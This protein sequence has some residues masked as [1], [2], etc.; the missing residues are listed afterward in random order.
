MIKQYF[1][2]KTIPFCKDIDTENIFLSSSMK[3]LFSRLEYMKQMRGI[4]LLTGTAGSGKTL[5]IRYFINSLNSNCYLPIY[6]PLTTVS[7]IDFYRQLCFK[8]TGEEEF[9]KWKCFE[10]IQRG[11]IDSVTNNKKVPVIV[12]DEAQLLKSENLFEIQIILNFDID[13][14]DPV[15]FILVG[16][17]Y[18]KDIIT[19]PIHG[20]LNQRFTLKYNITSLEKEEVKRYIEHHLKICGVTK[21]IFT[22]SS[23]EAIYNNTGG[24]PRGIGNIATKALTL[25]SIEKKQTITEEEIYKVSKEL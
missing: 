5:A 20:S 10:K 7:C 17:T 25:A 13:S 12:I 2:L 15:I 21:E 16:Q 6:T 4:M 3:E 9:Y 22:A 19:R 18:L 1:G 11:I 8:L 24:N 14:T 23:I